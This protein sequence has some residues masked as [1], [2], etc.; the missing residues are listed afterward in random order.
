M[1]ARLRVGERDELA[2][3]ARLRV[4]ERDELAFHADLHLRDLG[5]VAVG[6]YLGLCELR[7]LHFGAALG[8]GQTRLLSRELGHLL[9]RSL[10]G[11]RKPANRCIEFTELG[12]GHRVAQFLEHWA[13]RVGERLRHVFAQRGAKFLVDTI[14]VHDRSLCTRKMAGRSTGG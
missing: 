6:A 11:R 12:L 7:Q 1:H 14:G 2:L 8:G 4:G 10:L 13:E 5:H 3:H 9:F